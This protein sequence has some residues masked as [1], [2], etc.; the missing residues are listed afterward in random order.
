[1]ECALWKYIIH[2]MYYCGTAN[3]RSDDIVAAQRSMTWRDVACSAGLTRA[4][5]GVW[6]LI[7]YIRGRRK[8]GLEWWISKKRSWTLWKYCPGMTYR[9]FA[10]TSSE[11]RKWFLPNTCLEHYLK[12]LIALW[13]SI[14]NLIWNIFC[15]LLWQTIFSLHAP[16]HCR[17]HRLGFWNEGWKFCPDTSNEPFGKQMW[18]K[19]I[20][21]RLTCC[22]MWNWN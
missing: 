10:D 18:F 2:G 16:T 15:L 4:R 21:I 3:R 13:L 22:V 14:W 8:D 1:M 17:P 7:L 11:I 20:N 19:E 6:G 5:A 9:Y 12:P